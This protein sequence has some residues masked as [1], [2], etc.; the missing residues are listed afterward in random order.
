[1]LEVD[2]AVAERAIRHSLVL[3]ERL[4][5]ERQVFGEP[6]P[7]AEDSPALDRLVALLGRRT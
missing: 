2:D 3:L 7:V 4:P 6:Q 1:M 5:P